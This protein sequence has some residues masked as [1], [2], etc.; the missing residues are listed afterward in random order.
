[1]KKIINDK[2]NNANLIKTDDLPK[3]KRMKKVSQ[4]KMVELESQMKSELISINDR[5]EGLYQLSTDINSSVNE[6]A[7]KS[8]DK[9]IAV[10]TKVNDEIKKINE[11]LKNLVDFKKYVDLEFSRL[12]SKDWKKNAIEYE[13]IQKNIDGDFPTYMTINEHSEVHNNIDE[14]LDTYEKKQNAILSRLKY[15]IV[16]F[17][18]IIIFVALIIIYLCFKKF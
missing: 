6:K 11:S 12:D 15:C 8:L 10:E 13:N 9:S 4:A 1:M 2:N 3:K 17:I 7:T 14:R 16:S 18:I 5:I